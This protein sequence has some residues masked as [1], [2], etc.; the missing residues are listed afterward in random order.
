[1]GNNSKTSSGSR[2]GD[3]AAVQVKEEGTILSLLAVG[4][5]RRGTFEPYTERGINRLD[6]EY[7]HQ[8]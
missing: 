2:K 7:D 8:S 3:A 6:A 5:E 4:V 1:M